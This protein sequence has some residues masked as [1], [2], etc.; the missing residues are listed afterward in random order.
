MRSR[1]TRREFVKGACAGA[2]SFGLCSRIRRAIPTQRTRQPN[3]LLIM[4]DDMGFSDLGCYGGEIQTP[5]LDH[6]ASKGLRFT[7]FYNQGVCVAT[8]ASLL[9][10]LYAHQVGAAD[11]AR[12]H[13]E[14]SLTIAEVLRE[15]GYRTLMTGKWHNGLTPMK[16]GFDRY[17][18]LLSG[19]CNYF[20]PGLRRAG[21]GEP[22]RKYEGEQR[23]WGIDQRI[24]RPYTPEDRDFYST[25]A[26][27]DCALNYLETYCR[28]DNPFFLYVAYTAP[29]FPIQAKPED[30]AK[31]RGRYRVG[32]DVIR[33]QR[34]ER[35]VSMGLVEPGWGLS[36]RDRLAPKWT[37]AQ[38]EDLWDLKMAVYAAMVDRMDQGIGRI[39]RKIAEL[40]NEENTLV[41]FL[42]DNGGCG[43][44]INRTPGTPP[45]GLESYCTV[46]APW[47]NASNTPFRKYKVFTH[48]G[49]I[50]TPLIVYWPG[51][52]RKEG[53][54]TNQVGHVMDIVA[55]LIEAAG[56]DYP[57]DFH[58]REILP[59][60][61]K[62]LMPVFQGRQRQGH[63]ALFWELMGCRAARKGKWK[64]V[65]EGP[66]RVHIGI[67]VEKGKAGWELYDVEADR[68]ELNDLAQQH[69][70]KVQELDALWARWARRCGLSGMS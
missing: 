14:H 32:W 22:G 17:Y 58:G 28:G 3:M 20:N 1:I 34:Y 52:I 55:T 51:M 35:M 54:I 61:G 23:P 53:G 40:D 50:C 48:E 65:S 24:V 4:A 27:T 33:Q 60:E 16:F 29:H 63:E 41:L 49:G 39:L 56:T 66:E 25:D 44:Q 62:T 42:S 10:G 21:E 19:C 47:A 64:I 68:C 26:F 11:K 37:D 15:A 43:E 2:A 5:N 46:D 13:A 45:G 18:G 57:S 6:L 12:L 69:P 59:L 38:N 9:T 31:Y 30:I 36:Q 67:P 7:Q 70:Q 8:R